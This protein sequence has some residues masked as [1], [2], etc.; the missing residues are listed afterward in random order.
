MVLYVVVGDGS[1]AAGNGFNIIGVVSGPDV[2]TLL[3]GLPPFIS[4]G[5]EFL[6][7]LGGG[8]VH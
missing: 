6:M 3:K 7:K 8:H 2:L 4:L 1:K 5:G